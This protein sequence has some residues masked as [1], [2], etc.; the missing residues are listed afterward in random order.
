[1]PLYML[2]KIKLVGLAF[3]KL[4][5]NTWPLRREKRARNGPWET[6]ESGVKLGNERRVSCT[7]VHL[8]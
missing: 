8:N 3:F 1:M 6:G 7:G 2:L 5:K 4:Q